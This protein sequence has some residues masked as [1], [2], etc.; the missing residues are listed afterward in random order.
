MLHAFFSICFVIFSVL[1]TA[2]TP[3]NAVLSPDRMG[4]EAK[5][6]FCYGTG[7]ASSGVILQPYQRSLQRSVF[8]QYIENRGQETVDR[9]K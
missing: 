3:D 5:T 2:T 7:S 8:E 9:P 1:M 6:R 4:K